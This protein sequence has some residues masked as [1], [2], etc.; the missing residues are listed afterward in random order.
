MATID[1]TSDE[2]NRM[3]IIDVCKD[4]PGL[5]IV[6]EP[7][8]NPKPPINRG[9]V[10][11]ALVLSVSIALVGVLAVRAIDVYVA[12][13]DAHPA[14]A[15]AV[16]QPRTVV[17]PVAVAMPPQD[18]VALPLVQVAD[19]APPAKKRRAEPAPVISD[20][21]EFSELAVD[22]APRKKKK[23]SKKADSAGLPDEGPVSPVSDEKALVL[24]PKGDGAWEKIQ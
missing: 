3:L 10:A 1:V 15:L 23:K 16:D 8:L 13:R 2:F 9:M 12:A 20:A 4:V 18:L 17:A 21:A 7:M 22:E 14:P 5:R 24:K 11:R 19:T 6:A